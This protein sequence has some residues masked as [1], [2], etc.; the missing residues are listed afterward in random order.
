MPPG[1]AQGRQRQHRQVAGAHSANPAQAAAPA[2][3]ASHGVR[4]RI[5]GRPVG[6]LPWS[7]RLADYDQ[8]GNLHDDT[9]LAAR[10][11]SAATCGFMD[12]AARCPQPHRANHH[13]SGQLM[14]YQSGQLDASAHSSSAG[15]RSRL[16]PRSRHCCLPRR[17]RRSRAWQAG[18]MAAAVAVTAFRL[19]VPQPR[20]ERSICSIFRRPTSWKLG[21]RSR[22]SR[23]ETHGILHAAEDME[24]IG[25]AADRQQK[26]R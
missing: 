22:S 9:K 4:A 1:G 21:V 12:N 26:L 19:L 17:T 14:R 15:K 5:P 25:V 24:F 2:F 3:C 18:R 16:P 7:P 20:F 11:A 13:R 23:S 6:D 10:P 8:H